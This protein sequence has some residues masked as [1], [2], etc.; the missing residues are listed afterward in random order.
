MARSNYSCLH[1]SSRLLMLNVMQIVMVI[2][3]HE[4]AVSSS[5]SSFLQYN[6]NFE[7]IF[8]AM[9]YFFFW[10]PRAI[11]KTGR[12]RRWW[13]KQCNGDQ[14]FQFRYWLD[15]TWLDFWAR[16]FYFFKCAYGTYQF[17]I[18]KSK[19]WACFKML[20]CVK[21]WRFWDA[22]SHKM[23]IVDLTT[24]RQSFFRRPCKRCKKAKEKG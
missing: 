13:W 7:N 11:F 1:I 3:Y 24:H 2:S 15:L 18:K 20:R 4:Q 23:V 14:T 6:C 8:F 12:K 10:I 21:K 22:I 9:Q 5:S 16:F 17:A 19:T